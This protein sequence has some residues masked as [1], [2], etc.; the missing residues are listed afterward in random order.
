MHLR[1]AALC[2]LFVSAAWADQASTIARIHRDVIGGSTRIAELSALRATGVIRIGSRTLRIGI[3]AQRPNRVRTVVQAEGSTATQGY[4]GEHQP[5]QIS[6]KANPPVPQLMDDSAAR[7]FIADAE[8]DD[9]LVAPP[10]RGYTLDYAG[11]TEVDGRRM[12]RVLVTHRLTGPAELL[13][14]CETYFIV[15]RLWQRRQAKGREVPMEMRYADF[16]PVGGVILP[17]RITVLASG[18]P[19][20]ETVLEEVEAN[21]IISPFTFSLSA[22]AAAPKK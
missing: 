6:S 1:I 2:L 4:D 7:E 11:E 9:P 22:P 3:V 12:F 16:R 20:H 5:W 15:R 21:P 10:E 14:D 8:F 13:V 19:A 18:R 17:H